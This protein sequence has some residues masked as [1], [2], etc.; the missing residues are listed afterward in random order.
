[1][2]IATAVLLGVL[3]STCS[4]PPDTLE[5]VLE[6][7]QLRVVT[8]VGPTTY[9]RGPFGNE[10]PEYELVEG[11]RDFLE[12]KYNRPLQIDYQLADGLH[13]LFSQLNTGNAHIAAAG[14]TITPDRERY[15]R[16]GPD[17]Q[18]VSQY[19]VY[20]LNSGR[21][22]SLD[23]LSGKRLEVLAGSSF[24]TALESKRGDH[25]QLV[26]SENPHTTIGDLLLAVQT[27][28]LDYTV[29]DS[30]DFYV[31]RY[32]MPDLRKAIKL[33]SADKLAW[34]F[35]LHGSDRLTADAH[36]YFNEIKNNGLLERVQE[37][38]YGHTERFDYVGTRTFKRHYKS[39]L[40]D[41][42]DTFKQAA[43]LNGVDWRL[44]AAIGYQESHWNPDAVSPTGVAGLMMLTRA[45]AG[46]LGVEDRRNAKQSI[47]A[48]AE[49]FAQLYN[50]FEAIPEPD[51]TW[52]ALAAYN[53]G[54]GHVLDARHLAVRL[55]RDPDR[56][57]DI[58]D[59]LP[60]LA[61]REYYSTVRHGYARGW[62]PVRYVQNVRTYYEILSWLTP[63]E[64]KPSEM[65]IQA[66]RGEQPES[67][68]L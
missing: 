10:G 43:D 1:M 7:G 19:L 4:T 46:G 27:R 33:T 12:R 18:Q 56:W 22:H 39:R 49:Y 11:F 29:V 50:R 53:I 47:D 58:Q 38:Y 8:R 62:A 15:V 34:A 13:G 26:W 23:D 54:Y 3:V 37:R 68:T 55:G 60:L 67:A 25:P 59:M 28:E 24:V 64:I 14:L 57:L 30:T 40:P 6:S 66:A 32:Y 65:L 35:D 9:Y 20:R 2:R 31:H 63:N 5:E 61:D 42:L 21:P 44:L 16:F 52:L 45:T 48:G 41:Y 51:R 36:A 17:Y